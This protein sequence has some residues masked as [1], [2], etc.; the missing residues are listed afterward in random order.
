MAVTDA[1]AAE[2]VDCAAVT[3]PAVKVTVAVCV[4]VTASLVSVAVYV[5]ASATVSLT[6][7][8]ATP[9]PLVTPETVVIVEEPLALGER[10][11]LTRNRVR[12][13]VLQR[14]GDRRGG[15]AVGGD[16]ARRG[17]DRRA[18]AAVT[19]PTV[20]VT[21]AVCVHGDR[22]GRVGRGVGGGLGDRVL[23]RERRDAGAVR[24]TGDG[25]DRRGAAALRERHRLAGD[26][27][28]LRI[29][30]RDGDRRASSRRR[31]R[32]RPVRR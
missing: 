2:T 15:G 28:R 18:A 4:T 23:D 7:K 16:R 32:R 20:N 29:L 13:G 25:R 26:Q 19:G 24:D 30:E 14:H 17:A 1:G 6:V 11:R 27:V 10:H 9:E 31:R 12:L 22:V 3:A 5:V 8:V 21:D